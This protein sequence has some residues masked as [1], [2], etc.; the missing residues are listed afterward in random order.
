MQADACPDT[1]AAA[2]QALS[3]LSFWCP[4]L[5]IY[6]LIAGSFQAVHGQVTHQVR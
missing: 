1:G 4:R 6:N 3:G 5:G 2:L